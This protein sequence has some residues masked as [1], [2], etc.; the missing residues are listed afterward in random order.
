MTMTLVRPDLSISERWA[1]WE[2]QADERIEAAVAEGVDREAIF[3]RWADVIRDP[4]GMQDSTIIEMLDYA[5]AEV[6]GDNW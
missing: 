3:S 4:V 5:I 6:R 1:N 2:R